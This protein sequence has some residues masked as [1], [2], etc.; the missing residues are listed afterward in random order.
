MVT[1]IHFRDTYIRDTYIF[2]YYVLFFSLL[3][4]S[5]KKFSVRSP[6]RYKYQDG[7][8][9]RNTMHTDCNSHDVE[10]NVSV[11][12]IYVE[13][14]GSKEER[15]GNE[16]GKNELDEKDINGMAKDESGGNSIVKSANIKGK[17]ASM[18]L[19]ASK[20]VNDKSGVDNYAMSKDGY[21]FF[22]PLA[23][24]VAGSTSMS[25]GMASRSGSAGVGGSARGAKRLHTALNTPIGTPILPV[26]VLSLRVDRQLTRFPKSV[27]RE[28]VA[29][30]SLLDMKKLAVGVGEVVIVAEECMSIKPCLDIGM[31]ADEVLLGA[32]NDVNHSDGICLDSNGETFNIDQSKEKIF[33]DEIL[34]LSQVNLSKDEVLSKWKEQTI[35]RIWPMEKLLAGTVR[36]SLHGKL[37]KADW[38]AVNKT[39]LVM[40]IKEPIQIAQIVKITLI[41]KK[42]GMLSS[43][44]VPHLLRDVVEVSLKLC[45]IKRDLCLDIEGEDML[46]LKILQINDSYNFDF[47]YKCDEKTK[48]I[49]QQKNQLD[50]ATSETT[51]LFGM[52]FFRFD[53]YLENI[54]GLDKELQ[55]IR[56][57]VEL[58]LTSPKL[59]ESYGLSPP[60]GVL[61]H[62]P[63]GTGKTMIARAVC[64]NSKANFFTISGS[65]IVSKFV[66]ES[67]AKVCVL[68]CII[69]N[70]VGICF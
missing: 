27:G 63:P 45:H 1:W 43:S 3:M 51:F 31:D 33:E 17:E 32:P 16:F 54:G 36:L 67:E 18:C 8:L 42:N 65:Q 69:S 24:S 10:R 64:A 12:K 60:K 14:D 34:K 66:G 56:D 41:D 4:P 48:F 35:F 29:F 38:I 68:F 46:G 19:S 59:F 37:H 25:A 62:G 15:V 53:A 7:D 28:N 57:L 40:K 6:T 49:W 50:F 30:I 61:L 20:N 55:S 52:Q 47:I 9:D 21:K 26:D 23:H 39:V 44:S 11:E 58:P 2:T 22:T 13:N 70:L 5:R